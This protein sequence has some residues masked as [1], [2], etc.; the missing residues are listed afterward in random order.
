MI[1]KIEG[2]VISEQA[3]GETSKIINILTPDRG[4]IG[5]MAKGARKLKSDLANV[6]GKL[7]YGYFDIYYKS[8]KLSTLISADIINSFKNIRKDI[9]KISYAYFLLELSSQVVKHNQNKHVFNYLISG[10][11]KI[12]E[13]FDFM[14]ITN[15]LELK[16]LDLLGVMPVLDSCSGCGK[17]TNILTLSTIKGGYVCN[18]CHTVE[19]IV[20]EK[21]IKLIRMFYYVD[22]DKISKLQI[23]DICKNEINEFLDNYYDQY[24]GLFLKSKSFLR[25]LN[26]L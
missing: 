9:N 6:S 21:T 7:N 23:S 10:L 25:D 20:S 18:S 17:T 14:T 2:I 22:I 4:I 8:D 13:G 15:I 16:Y 26:K 12:D 19:K 24:T 3:Y 5:L 1:E 11:K